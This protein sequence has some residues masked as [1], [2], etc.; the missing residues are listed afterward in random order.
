V[1]TG[2]IEAMTIATISVIAIWELMPLSASSCPPLKPM[3]NSKYSENNFG[4]G[5]GIS[6]SDFKKTASI[7]KKKNNTGGLRM[8]KRIKLPSIDFFFP[9]H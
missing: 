9:Q 1:Y 2:T 4:K 5:W 7:P 8:L 3:D 6:K